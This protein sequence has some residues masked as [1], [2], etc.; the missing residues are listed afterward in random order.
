MDLWKYMT[1]ET[2]MGNQKIKPLYAS[3]DRESPDQLW[4]KGFCH[5]K[6]V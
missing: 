6:E 2:S 5:I 3:K 1:E 4:R